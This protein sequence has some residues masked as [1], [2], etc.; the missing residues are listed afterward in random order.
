M[1]NFISAEWTAITLGDPYL[2]AIQVE[3]MAAPQSGDIFLLC[4]VFKAQGAGGLL[5]FGGQPDLGEV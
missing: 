5:H 3:N 1:N 4:I 2:D